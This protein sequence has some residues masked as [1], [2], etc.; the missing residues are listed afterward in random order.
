MTNCQWIYKIKEGEGSKGNVRNKARLIVKGFAQKDGADYNK[1]FSHEV[2]YT[3]IR[4]IIT[5]VTQFNW[6]LDQLDA[7]IAFLYREL[8]EQIYMKKPIGL[9]KVILIKLYVEKNLCM[10]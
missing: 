7:K 6:K 4:T 2:K 10:V 9:I 3:T 8:G 1:I 5:L